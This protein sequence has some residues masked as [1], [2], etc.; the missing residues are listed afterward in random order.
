MLTVTRLPRD[1]QG[2]E[3]VLVASLS[4]LEPEE[5]VS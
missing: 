3:R 2:I 1:L 5:P 4:R